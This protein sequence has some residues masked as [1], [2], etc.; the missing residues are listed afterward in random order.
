MPIHAQKRGANG[1]VLLRLKTML[2]VS[3]PLRSPQTILGARVT[4]EMA[5]YRQLTMANSEAAQHL[6]ILPEVTD[7]LKRKLW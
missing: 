1:A 7:L 4:G 3:G 5:I 2:I 6:Q